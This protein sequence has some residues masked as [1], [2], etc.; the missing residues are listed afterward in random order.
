MQQDVGSVR[1]HM[2]VQRCRKR[3]KAGLFMS[4]RLT[5][6]VLAPA[7]QLLHKNSAL[8]ITA[9]APSGLTDV[10]CEQSLASHVAAP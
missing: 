9:P 6:R 4:L 2:E 7:F 1:R 3:R 8:N 5:H 10:G